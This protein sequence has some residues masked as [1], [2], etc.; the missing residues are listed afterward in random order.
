MLDSRRRKD[1]LRMELRPDA[2]HPRDRCHA[3]RHGLPVIGLVSADQCCFIG[4]STDRRRRG[5]QK[6]QSDGCRLDAGKI[7]TEDV[8]ADTMPLFLLDRRCSLFQ[9]RHY[10]AKS[11]T[12]SFDW[13]NPV[14]SSM[15]RQQ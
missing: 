13:I 2:R 1:L 3:S 4:E 9:K 7:E 11:K 10:V 8:N 15:V 12:F 6:G 14:F 5:E